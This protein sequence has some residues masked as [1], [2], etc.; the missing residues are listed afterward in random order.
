MQIVPV[1]KNDDGNIRVFA[2]QQTACVQM[3]R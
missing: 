2:T 1:A 3:V